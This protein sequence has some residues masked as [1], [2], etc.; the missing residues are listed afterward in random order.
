MFSQD[1]ELLLFLFA[2]NSH[3][4]LLRHTNKYVDE[5]GL[6]IPVAQV[7]G[8]EAGLTIVVRQLL[9]FKPI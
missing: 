2:F 4:C 9:L 3:I 7:V 8:L 6:A 1:V 5:A